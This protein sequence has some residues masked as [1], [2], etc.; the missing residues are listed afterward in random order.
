MSCRLQ[1]KHKLYIKMKVNGVA[2]AIPETIKV[3]DNDLSK[4]LTGHKSR[5]ETKRE[6]INSKKNWSTEK[7]D[8]ALVVTYQVED[9]SVKLY[10]LLKNRIRAPRSRGRV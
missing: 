3:S 5:S 8:Y 1:M 10:E 4:S 6:V 2:T 7:Q 9:K